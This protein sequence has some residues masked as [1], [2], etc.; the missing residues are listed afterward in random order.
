MSP[1]FKSL[2]GLS[3]LFSPIVPRDFSRGVSVLNSNLIWNVQTLLNKSLKG[4]C[5]GS[6]VHFNLPLKF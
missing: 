1:G 4:L 2:C 5:H 6:P 3:L